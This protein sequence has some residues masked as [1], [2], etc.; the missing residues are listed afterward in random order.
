MNKLKD[1]LVFKKLD[2]YILREYVGPF[3][4]TFF[5]AWFV[6]VMQFLWK[7]I[8]DLIGKGL[9]QDIIWKFMWYTSSTLIPMA[10]PLAILLSSI[11]TMGKFGE[12]SELTAAKSTGISLFRFF[13]STIVFSV[14]VALFAFYYS[15]YI[16]TKT[17]AI[18]DTMLTDIRTLKPSLLIKPNQ[19]YNGISG[20]SLRVDAKNDETGELYG[21]KIYQH[22]RGNGNESITLAKKGNLAQSEDGKVLIFKL[23]SV[24]Q[25]RDEAS[26]SFDNLKYPFYITRFDHFEKRFDLSQFQLSSSSQNPDAER[27]AMNIAQLNYTIDSMKRDQK[28]KAIAYDTQFAIQNKIFAPTPKATASV[29][30]S[31]SLARLTTEDKTRLKLIRTN[32][33][34]NVK[35]SLFTYNSD[36]KYTQDIRQLYQIE[37][38]R[39]FT[40]AISCIV[41]FFVGA[42]L[43]AIIKKGG[44]GLPMFIAVILFIIYYAITLVGSTLAQQNTINAFVGMWASTLIYIPLGLFLTIKAKNDSQLTNIEGWSNNISQWYY[45]YVDRK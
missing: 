12:S 4:V 5:I 7:Y 10:L 33:I 23:D 2:W 24:T 34:R 14:F 25:Y 8:D 13:K 43:G 16:F 11:M 6:L 44:I 45:R 22:T 31:D 27:L 32:K 19:F 36:M 39:K 9:S 17:K 15:N 41:L 30:F 18:A 38:H 21:I 20:I 40:L 3:L 28:N 42:P 37:W 35:N 29:R 26:S 1:I